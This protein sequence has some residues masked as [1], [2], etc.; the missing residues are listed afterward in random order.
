MEVPPVVVAVPLEVVARVPVVLW[1]EVVE[2]AAVE[3]PALVVE[4]LVPLTLVPPE[5]EL[6]EP[7][8]AAE[9]VLP[10]PEPVLLAEASVFEAFGSSAASELQATINEPPRSKASLCIVSNEPRVLLDGSAI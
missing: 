4:P 1:L 3:L 9:V 5:V 7:E 2:P 10:E 8:L 6:V